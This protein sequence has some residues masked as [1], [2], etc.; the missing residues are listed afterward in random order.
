MNSS[1]VRAKAGPSVM[2]QPCLTPLIVLRVASGSR[3]AAAFA[4]S[5]Q[6]GLIWEPTT[7]RT[8]AGTRPSRLQPIGD[9]PGLTPPS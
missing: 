6:A 4:P 8:D 1:A 9:G 5:D 3:S 2:G 7:R